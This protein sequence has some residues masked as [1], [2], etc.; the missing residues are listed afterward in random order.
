M[1]IHAI[2]TGTELLNGSTVNTNQAAAGQMLAGIGLSVNRA[3]TVGDDRLQMVSAIGESLA[4]GA[5]T[6]LFCG[7]LGSTEDDFT[8]E[9]VAEYFGLPLHKEEGLVRFLCS[10]YRRHHPEG[11]IPKRTFRQAMVPEGA[12][13]LP[14]RV[15]SAVGFRIALDFAGIARQ[16]FLLPGPPSEFIPMFQECVLPRLTADEPLH[17]VKFL[18]VGC[19]ELQLEEIVQSLDFPQEVQVAYC[20]IAG[21]TRLFLS[22]YDPALLQQC[23]ESVRIKLPCPA[24]DGELTLAGAVIRLLRQQRRTVGFAESCT[25]GM[26]AADVVNM[27]GASEV[28]RGG[29]V[30]YNNEIKESLL[31]VSPEILQNHGAVS[32]EC[33]AAMASGAAEKLGVSIAGAVTGIAGPDGGTQEKPVGLVYTAICVDGVVTVQKNQ[34]HGD[35]T[36]IRLRSQ[37]E[38]LKMIYF[39]ISKDL[40]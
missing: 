6:L 33:A 26:I 39:A 16:I 1:N 8:R 7:G 22:G 9:V 17:M 29:I 13:I 38:M 28:F 31:G 2:F 11:P 40:R 24:P 21:G 23:A 34:F 18:A 4:C 12:E 35:R 20:A 32:E 14:N 10:C 5:D 15:G 27:P 25:G 37:A 36:A 30:A 3:V 19:G